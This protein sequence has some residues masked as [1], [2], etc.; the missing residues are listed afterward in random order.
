MVTVL[1]LVEVHALVCAKHGRVQDCR[2][3]FPGSTCAPQELSSKALKPHA[4]R[5]GFVPT[6]A[7]NPKQKI[8]LFCSLFP[9]LWENCRTPPPPPPLA[10]RWGLDQTVQREHA[11]SESIFSPPSPQNKLEFA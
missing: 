6:A 11:E 5:S 2:A 1:E 7:S 8:T 9:Q 3:C 10:R 4:P